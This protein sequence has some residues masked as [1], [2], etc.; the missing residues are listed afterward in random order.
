M[1]CLKITAFSDIHFQSRSNSS[2]GKEIL[3]CLRNMVT[4]IN[5]DIKPDIVC[6][7]GDLVSDDP[8]ALNEVASVL[9]LIERPV[10]VIPGNH[11]GNRDDFFTIFPPLPDFIDLAG[12]RLIP[13]ADEDAADFNSYRTADQIERL[14]GLVSGFDGPVISLQHVPLLFD[15]AALA[16]SDFYCINYKE[17]AEAVQGKVTHTL[18]GHFHKGGI[19]CPE[20]GVC[21]LI[22][23]AFYK[24]PFN[25][26]DITVGFDY[27]DI[28]IKSLF[29]G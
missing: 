29:D 18:S 10:M 7:L 11:D 6:V 14:V 20:N 9:N 5:R 22:C 27:T 2:G 21:Q 1:E 3:S 28:K 12:C 26:L 8:P 25:F 19:F 15:Q 17:I 4:E 24:E 13:F 16:Y 23:P